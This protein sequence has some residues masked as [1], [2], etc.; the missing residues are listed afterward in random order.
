MENENDPKQFKANHNI[1]KKLKLKIFNRQII[2]R[3]L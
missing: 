2:G 3:Y 1:L